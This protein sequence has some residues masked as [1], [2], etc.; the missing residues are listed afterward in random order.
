[1]SGGG[2]ALSSPE[3]NGITRESVTPEHALGRGFSL[4]GEK[5]R[6]RS[7]PTA[8]LLY[9]GGVFLYFLDFFG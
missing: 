6:K 9:R 2:R 7:F 3:G 8:T 4:M 5:R 1:M